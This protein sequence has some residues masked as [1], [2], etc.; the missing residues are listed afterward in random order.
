MSAF[1]PKFLLDPYDRPARLYPGLLVFLPIAVLLV[2]LYGTAHIIVSSVLSILGFCGAGYALGRVS[3]D[4]GKRIQDKLFRK[5]GGAPTTQLLRYRDTSIDVYTKE[6]FHGVL[7]QGL[8]KPLPAAEAERA[9]PAAA[10]ELYRAATVWLIA[11][12]RDT[13]KFPLVF[14]ENVA[15]GFQRNCLGLRCYGIAMTAICIA[16]ALFHAKVLMVTPPYFFSNP[17]LTLEPAEMITLGVSAMMLIAWLF[18]LNEGALKRTG[19]SYAER[20]L[21]SCDHL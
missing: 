5:W 1:I 20:L 4:A 8:K 13:K 16:W 2:C 19:F 10:D 12:T 6:R 11:Q 7:A 18:L 14:K 17:M 21:Q 15:F 3:R 9:D